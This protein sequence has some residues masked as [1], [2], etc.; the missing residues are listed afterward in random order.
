V[1]EARADNHEVDLFKREIDLAQYA[2]QQGYKLCTESYAGIKVMQEP[3]T[4]HRIVVAWD[5]A[6][7]HWVYSTLDS[8]FLSTGEADRGT[9]I[10]FVQRHTPQR[11]LEA[12]LRE[13]RSILGRDPA[14]LSTEP[15]SPRQV[16]A[17]QYAA[18]QIAAGSRYL[19]R[20]GVW[21][22]TQ[23]A[24]RFQGCWRVDAEGNVLFPHRG[25]QGFGGC[26]VMGDSH[27]RSVAAGGL[28]SS[29][30]RATDVVLVCTESALDALSYYQLYA[31]QDAR[32]VSLGGPA[33]PEQLELLC[34]AAAKLPD[35]GIVVLAFDRDAAGKAL[36]AF[37]QQVLEREARVRV[38]QH[39]PPCE[40]GK[41]WNDH[42]LERARVR[43]GSHAP[44]PARQASRP[45]QPR[46]PRG[47]ELTR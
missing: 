33:M 20:K 6:S 14:G 2:Q 11:G 4:R 32:Y 37:V 5:R 41:S 10:D 39:A 22:Q 45:P 7:G 34:H 46:S 28:W 3:L 8:E 27:P 47:P 19:E 35:N 42:V 30:G 38:Q 26:E 18:A 44:P 43:A 40:L 9:I 1:N 13:C 36:G 23:Q 29:R 15:E 31:R 21:L 17:A 16:T 24:A 25:A 12:A